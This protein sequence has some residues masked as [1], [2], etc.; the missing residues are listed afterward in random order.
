MLRHIYL[1]LTGL[2]VSKAIAGFIVFFVSAL[3]HEYLVGVPLHILSY[4]AFIA[5]MSQSP[6]IIFQKVIES[7]LRIRNSELGNLVFWISF[8]F[9]G[10][11]IVVFAYYYLCTT[12]S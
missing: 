5:M 11:P 7:K 4:W 9:V 3:Y 2:G 12:K 8:C 6:L 10:Q 1:P